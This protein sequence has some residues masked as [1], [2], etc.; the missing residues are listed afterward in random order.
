MAPDKV[1]VPVNTPDATVLVN[2]TDPLGA[3]N[4]PGELSVTVAVQVEVWLMATGDVHD[5][6]VPVLRFV[7]M[8]EAVFWL[9]L[10]AASALKVA[11]SV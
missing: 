5:T 9:V 1:H 10:C 6:V 7:T 4:V 3:M 2:V 11:V 8:I